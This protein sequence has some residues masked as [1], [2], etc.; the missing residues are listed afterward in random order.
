MLLV[1]G[2]IGFPDG[3]DEMEQLAHAVAEGDVAAFAFGLE[4]AIEGA[5]GGVV[6][7]GGSSGIPQVGAN[8]IVAFAGHVQ[9]AGGQGLA[10]LVDAGAVFFGKDAEIID[11][12]VGRGEAIDVDDLGDQ[13]GGRGVADAGD[14]D[15]LDVSR[16]G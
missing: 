9:R 16:G 1:E 2:P 10:V 12:V 5:D 8:Q 15:D 3:E 6:H 4:P 13:D 11:Q 7:D 14:G